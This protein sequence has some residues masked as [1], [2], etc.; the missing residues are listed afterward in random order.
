MNHTFLGF[1]ESRMGVIYFQNII[2]IFGSNNIE[3]ISRTSSLGQCRPFI[4]FLFKHLRVK[5]LGNLM[6]IWN[7]L[8]KVVSILKD[9][10]S[11]KDTIEILTTEIETYFWKILGSL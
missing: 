5:V 10:S 1:L 4:R 3:V 6:M 7:I 2:K 8:N 11:I 9:P